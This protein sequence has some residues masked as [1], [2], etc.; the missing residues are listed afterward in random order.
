[1]TGKTPKTEECLLTFRP[2]SAF[3]SM[4]ELHASHSSDELIVAELT[5]H[6]LALQLYVRSLLPGEATAGDVAQQA[7]ATI[8]LKRGEF[9][10]GTNFKAW[11]FSIARY[12]V[13][14][15]RKRQARDARLVFSDELEQIVEAELA[16]ADL[17]LQERHDALRQCLEKLREQ[18]RQLLLHRYSR[19]G[20]LAEFADV[21]G[22]SVGGLK[23]TLHRLRSALLDCV[24]RRLSAG[25]ATS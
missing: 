21:V 10:L 2:F 23:V 1:M 25:E 14:N 3:R 5:A 17:R 16:D 11:A 6:Q 20:T 12:E 4:D 15:Y 22:R 8:W 24:E 9:E 13:L 18:D 7:N 19:G